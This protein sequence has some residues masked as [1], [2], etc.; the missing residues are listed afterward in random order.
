L[1]IFTF[2]LWTARLRAAI[3]VVCAVVLLSPSH[4]RASLFWDADASA[5]GNDITSGTALGGTGVWDGTTANWYN[6]TTDV[7][8]T[9]GSDAFFR[10]T[11]GIVTLTAPHTFNSLSFKTD[12]FTLTGSSLSGSASP[13]LFVVDSGVTATI[14]STLTGG[15]LMYKLGPGTLALTNTANTNTATTSDG[16]WR[17]DGGTLRISSDA[18]LGAPLPDEATNTVTDIQLNQSTIQ[19]DASFDI[20]KSRRTKLGTNSSN[21]LGDA[22]IDTH[23]NNVTWFGS[24]QGGVGSLLVT[25]TGSVPGRLALGTDHLASVN[26]FGSALPGG[27]V[28]LTVTGGAI[29]QTS[30]QVT[31]TGGELGSETGLNGAVLAIK[32]DNGQIRSESGGYTF[33]RNLILG[34]G[35]GSLDTGS[36]DQ[37]FAGSAISG[38]GNLTKEGLGKL[39]LDNSTATWTGQTRV[40]GGTLQIGRGGSNGLLPGTL[41][42][43]GSVLLGDATLRFYRNADK[44]F[45]T[46]I[47]G[48]GRVEIANDSG[49][50][51][52][53][54]SDNSWT[55][56][57]TITSGVLMI[58]QGNPGEP[59]S[60]IA[61]VLDNASLVFNRVEDVSY[62]GSISGSGTV[63]K[64]AAGKLTLTGASTYTGTTQVN[65]G[66]LVAANSSGSATGSGIVIIASGA[67][68]AGNGSLAGSVGINAG[69]H[70]APGASAGVLTVGKLS[71]A[72]NSNLDYEL[73]PVIASDLTMISDSG[74][75][76]LPGGTVNI[77]ALAGFGAGEYRLLDYDT[78]FNGSVANLSIGSA[79]SGFTYSFIDNTATTSVDLLV[80]PVPE[81]A[82]LLAVLATVPLIATR[83]RRA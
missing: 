18:S 48:G 68:L 30:G 53:L 22:V 34:P 71:L 33:Q 32:L 36:W 17:I 54:V 13:A 67:T 60:I 41:A 43:P 11:P 45:Y 49:A 12:G 3:G 6:L 76:S 37:T 16:G 73:G 8:W 10:G 55:G 28:N 42:S 56:L 72:M 38:N 82:S 69:G 40:H 24:I 83:R 75:L 20:S 74:G 35:G 5:A 80:S 1:S 46:N 47:S 19:F 77:T 52:R 2:E 21:H 7:P 62:G 27:T 79:P 50:A 66:T 15:S 57:T 70:L 64:L 29:L 51:V 63:T 65:A 78:F 25:N 26:P 9:D 4:S 58:G 23:G 59:G 14:A 31:P 81:P 61:D 39:T 44:T